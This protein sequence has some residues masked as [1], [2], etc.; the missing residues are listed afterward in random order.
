MAHSCEKGK[1]ISRSCWY[2]LFGDAE[3]GLFRLEPR[4]QPAGEVSDLI[5][6]NLATTDGKHQPASDK[7]RRAGRA[8]L[9]PTR[10]G[11]VG[12]SYERFIGLSV[13]G[14]RI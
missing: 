3:V 9:P 14:S 8:A 13:C 11:V 5:R 10:R 1:K 6:P 12:L 4:G 7:Y 2:I